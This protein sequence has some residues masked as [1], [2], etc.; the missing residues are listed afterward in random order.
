MTWSTIKLT[1]KNVKNVT[2]SSLISDNILE[3]VIWY[4][5]LITTLS[6]S[7]FYAT[8]LIHLPTISL[9]LCVTI[10]T[11][12]K[13]RFPFYDKAFS[14]FRN[15]CFRNF[16]NTKQKK[17]LKNVITLTFWHNSKCY[18]FLSVNIKKLSQN[19]LVFFFSHLSLCLKSF[20]LNHPTSAILCLNRKML[21]ILPRFS[22][23]CSH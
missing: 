20:I 13:N 7:F 3:V 14:Q 12:C 4:L 23:K 5:C 18:S 17:F 15:V 1:F 19:R 21:Q 16:V 9:Y 11:R 10:C 22:N 8:W 6:P 2:C